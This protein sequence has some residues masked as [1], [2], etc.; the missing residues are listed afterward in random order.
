MSLRGYRIYAIPRTTGT[1]RVLVESVNNNAYLY[2]ENGSIATLSATDGDNLKQTFT[3]VAD[4]CGLM[5]ILRLSV[6]TPAISVVD[7]YLIVITEVKSVGKI[8]ESDV[9]KV[10]AVKFLSLNHEPTLV[11]DDRIPELARLLSSEN[12]Y[13]ATSGPGNLF[14]LTLSA[15]R[16]HDAASSDYRF[17][18]NRNLHF[19][20]E[21]FG[22][23]SDDWFVRCMCGSVL[24][25]TIYV[26]HRTAKVAIISRLSCERVGTRF[27]VRGANDDGQVANF[28]ETEQLISFENRES[29]FVQIRGSVPLFWEQPG[30]QVGSHSIRMRSIEASVPALERHFL[31]LKKLY[32]E[33][34]AV[35]L[36]G[37]KE[38]ERKLSEAFKTLLHGSSH[39]DVEMINFDYHAQMKVSKSSI[40]QLQ[41]KLDP[42]VDNWQ[43]YLSTDGKPDKSQ[44]GVIRTNCL[45]CLDRTNC[46]QTLIGMKALTVQLADLEVEKFKAKISQRFE[47]T[48]KEIW[49]KNGDQCSIIYAGTGAL[50]GKSKLKDASRSIA[51]TFQNNLMDSAKQESFDLFLLGNGYFDDEFDKACRFLPVQMIKECPAALPEL[52]SRR[53]EM[54]TR[55]PLSVFCGTWNVNGGKH[56][57]VARKD[58]S[59]EEWIFGADWDAEGDV[60]PY[61]IVV[62]GLEEIVDLNATN[63]V[64]ASTTNQRLFCEQV[65]R[66]LNE[67]SREKFIILGCEQLVGVC[68]ILCVRTQ[69]LPRVRGLAISDVKTGMGGATG[70]KGSVAI[71]LTI[72]ATSVLFICSHFAAGQHEVANRN[73]DYATA[74]RKLRFPQ[75]R[76]VDSHDVIFWLGDFNYRISMPGGEIKKYV[77]QGQLDALIPYDQLTEQRQLGNVFKGFE[78]APLKFPPTYKYDTFSDIYDTSEKARAPAWTDRVLWRDEPTEKLVQLLDYRTAPLKSSD[79][80]PVAA[81]FQLDVLKVNLKKCE[82]IFHDVVSSLGPP[83]CMI[84]V[85]IEGFAA[86][87]EFLKDEVLSKLQELGV[88]V[89]LYTI[90]GNFMKIA[91]DYGSSALAALSM[92]GTDINDKQHRISVQLRSPDWEDDWAIRMAPA[93][94]REPSCINLSAIEGLSIVNLALDDDEVDDTVSIA[95]ARSCIDFSTSNNTPIFQEQILLSGSAATPTNAAPPTPSRPATLPP[96]PLS[97]NGTTNNVPAIPPRPSPANWPP[98][99]S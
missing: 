47:E 9:Y 22:I 19:P 60:P 52:I 14:D 31:Q 99:F 18:W 93:F 27:N 61:D 75:G 40:K 87:P 15:Q 91:F 4:G 63:M 37:S 10:A 46:V 80:R 98:R 58:N 79:H 39:N 68:L 57:N 54:S 78:E 1:Y 89:T 34:S 97:S 3:K 74:V 83:D 35:N 6:K 77:E 28:V 43:C 36:L 96:R 92:D 21:R 53:D 48:L 86:F 32:N 5:G 13:F 25:R 85:S 45:D 42:M 44:T 69:L 38:G 49:Q 51:R 29:S 66:T 7:T 24:I 71:R 84:L 12:F 26:G 76:T 70:N 94:R 56:L 64:K 41:A 11:T 81:I 67:K 82:E 23:N 17:F 88:T 33:V 16:R 65:K 50:E 90:E 72:D 8:N 2:I 59:F 62:I 20:L 95:S 55:Q 73:D 30:I